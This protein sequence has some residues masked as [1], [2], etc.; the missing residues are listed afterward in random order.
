[1][2]LADRLKGLSK[3]AEDATVEHKDQIQQ[4]VQKAEAVAEERTGGK[5]HEQIRKAGAK[6]DTFVE[7]LGETEKPQKTETTADV[8]GTPRAS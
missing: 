2:G 4:A 1:M 3:K 5:Y 8:E 7:G 6:A